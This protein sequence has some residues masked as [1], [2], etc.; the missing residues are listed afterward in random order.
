MIILTS[1]KF[2]NIARYW[3][4][5]LQLC[6]VP[7]LSIKTTLKWIPISSYYAHS[8]KYRLATFKM[9]S[10]FFFLVRCPHCI[11]SYIYYLGFHEIGERE[12]E[13]S[14]TW[15]YSLCCCIFS[16]YSFLWWRNH[17]FLTNFCLVLNIFV[18]VFFDIMILSLKTSL[19]FALEKKN[20][21]WNYF[22]LNFFGGARLHL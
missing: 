20:S 19:I 5:M 22:Q 6:L 2:I 4:H 14:Y 8:T 18:N 15:S 3:Y 17:V 11:L 16:F 9:S 10:T 12:R 7:P 1:L 13:N 21:N